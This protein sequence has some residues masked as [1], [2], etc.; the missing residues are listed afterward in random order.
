MFNVFFTKKNNTLNYF[1][2]SHRYFQRKVIF[3]RHPVVFMTFTMQPP[4][5]FIFCSL[6]EAA[7]KAER[8]KKKPKPKKKSGDGDGDDGGVVEGVDSRDEGYEGEEED[9]GGLDSDHD[10]DDK[11]DISKKP[12]K[13]EIG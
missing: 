13:W 8:R 9:E 3:S 2:D 4:D 7:L 12:D 11:M 10:V 5:W 1:H 6:A